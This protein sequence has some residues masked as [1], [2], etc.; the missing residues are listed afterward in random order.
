MNALHLSFYFGALLSVVA[1]LLS[2]LRGKVLFYESSQVAVAVILQ[3]SEPIE[4]WELFVKA[5]KRLNRVSEVQ[6]STLGFTLPELYALKV[7]EKR[8]GCKMIELAKEL[9]VT[10][11]AVTAL[12][13]SLEERGLVERT[14]S[15]EDRRVVFV[16]I[17][18]KGSQVLKEIVKKRKE[19][20]RRM[21]QALSQDELAQLVNILTKLSAQAEKI[22]K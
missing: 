5:W 15:N 7:L 21:T 17:T 3:T 4:L 2:A 20:M 16:R 22:L 18:E 6:L 14:R 12:I 13:D 9:L 10:Q 19:F 8:G 1:A 11:P